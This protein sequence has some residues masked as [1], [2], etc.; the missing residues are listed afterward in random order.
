MAER[1]V[2]L[3]RKRK[4]F[5][6]WLGCG[7]RLHSRGL[8][9]RFA[10]LAPARKALSSAADY[11]RRNAMAFEHIKYEQDGP[12]VIVTLNRPDK[13]NA[14][15]SQMGAEIEDAFRQADDDDSVRVIIVTGAGRGF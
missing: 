15:T 4:Y 5:S 9:G 1:R 6:G 13:L 7:T 8:C 3:K 10:G 14:Y 11:N 2:R 12:I